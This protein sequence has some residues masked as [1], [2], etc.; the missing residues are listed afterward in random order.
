M[1]ALLIVLDSVG[2]GDAP[3]AAEYGDEGANTLA[4]IFEREPNL[5]L[6]TLDSLGLARLFGRDGDVRASYGR[7]RE[8]SAG[9]DTTTGHWEL[10]GVILE[11]PF[12]VYERFPDELVH[13]IERDADIE[14]IGNYPRSGT[15]ILDELGPEHIRRGSPILYTSADSVL[16][17]AGH[18]EV[19]AIDRL[20]EICEIARRHANSFRI[21]RVIARP[22]VGSEGAFKRTAHRHDF[23]FQP[24]RTVLNAM[25]DAKRD[26]IGVGKISDIFAGSGIT[27]SH[28]TSS[29]AEGMSQI[30]RLWRER[31]DGLIFANLVD[32]D[33]IFGHR[34]EVKG[35]ANALRQFDDWLATFVDEIASDDLVIITADHGNDP[36]FRGSDHTREQVPLFVLHR[37]ER[38]D[39]GTRATYA[40]AAATL[41]DYFQLPSWPK[42]CSFLS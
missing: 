24:P 8:Q 20:Y 3:D 2:I 12:A 34:R 10:A 25:S 40:D 14:F 26:V 16:Q 13:A 11:E 15:A 21:G 30:A 23:S 39:L 5:Q 27:E 4:H 9:K 33:M 7:M 32:F 6:P 17:I 37:T 36:T 38:R 41:A 42:G 28:P 1:R 29:N 31:D 35:Y 19:I 18:E 22:F